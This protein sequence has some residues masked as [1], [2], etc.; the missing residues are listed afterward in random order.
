M[1]YFFKLCRLF[2][3]SIFY[4]YINDINNN[5]IAR[6]SNSLS[7]FLQLP[8]QLLNLLLILIKP[9]LKYTIPINLM[10]H[11]L[12]IRIAIAAIPKKKSAP[13][14]HT[15]GLRSDIEPK[16]VELRFVEWVLVDCRVLEDVRPDGEGFLLQ[17]EL[18]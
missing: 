18:V 12:Q 5:R 13:D 14:R 10:S 6:N 1:S 7:P 8:L 11:D 15:F 17:L 3:L 9:P 16:L 2:I 4:I